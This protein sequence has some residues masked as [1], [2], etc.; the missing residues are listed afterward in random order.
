MSAVGALPDWFTPAGIAEIVAPSDLYSVVAMTMGQDL[1]GDALVDTW[2]IT[3]TVTNR[4]GVFTFVVPLVGFRVFESP[5]D[6]TSEAEIVNAIY[7]I[8]V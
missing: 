4:P 7:N 1:A 5:I 6:L 3:F 2:E 8:Q